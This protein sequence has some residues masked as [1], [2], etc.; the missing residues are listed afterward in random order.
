M[1]WCLYMSVDSVVV[2]LKLL[3]AVED[4]FL[5]VCVVSPLVSHSLPDSCPYSFNV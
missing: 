1:D 5:V 4:I 3:G 2:C